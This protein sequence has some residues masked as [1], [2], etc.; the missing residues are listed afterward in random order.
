MKTIILKRISQTTEATHGVLIY[1]GSPICVTLELP[2]KDNMLNVSCIPEGTYGCKAHLDGRKIRLIYVSGRTNIQIHIGNYTEDIQ[3]C[4]LVGSSFDCSNRPY[5]YNSKA[6]MN[7]LLKTLGGKDNK[8]SFK[9]KIIQAHRDE[10]LS[11]EY[12]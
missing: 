3:G 9:L 2:W 1:N 8:E 6:A 7:A 4:I 5:I 10:Y 11:Y 12:Q